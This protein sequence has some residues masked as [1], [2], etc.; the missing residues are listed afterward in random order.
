MSDLGHYYGFT[1]D[2]LLDSMSLE[3]WAVYYS[4]IPGDKLTPNTRQKEPDR[5][6]GVPKG[7][8]GRRVLSK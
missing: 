8:D 1:P 5:I 7:P 6:I 4:Y 2:Y 3:Q